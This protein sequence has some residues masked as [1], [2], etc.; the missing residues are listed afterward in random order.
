MLARFAPRSKGEDALISRPDFSGF[1]FFRYVNKA[2]HAEI[3]YIRYQRFF[4]YSTDIKSFD[5]PS[6]A[7]QSIKPRKMR[8]SRLFIST[9]K[10]FHS[11]A[12]REW[13]LNHT[14]VCPTLFMYRKKKNSGKVVS[15]PTPLGFYCYALIDKTAER[16]AFGFMFF[17]CPQR[18]AG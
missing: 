5:E 13:V 10:H 9:I 3:S 12:L 7:H 6:L 2:T 18:I 15:R 17:R 16:V 4:C 11:V 14:L 8:F 1:L